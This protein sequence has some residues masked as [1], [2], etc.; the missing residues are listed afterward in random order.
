MTLNQKTT[1]MSNLNE[2]NSPDQMRVLMKR[3]RDGALTPSVNETST[4]EKDLGVR[5]MLKITRN[6]QENVNE[7]T[8]Q[9]R[10]ISSLSGEDLLKHNIKFLR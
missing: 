9:S 4:P 2:K 7:R 5:D 1:K 6:L 8:A 3:M 10:D